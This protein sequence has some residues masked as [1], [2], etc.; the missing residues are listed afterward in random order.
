[1]NILVLG[2]VILDIFYFSRSIRNAPEDPTVPIQKVESTEYK[3]GGAANVALNLASLGANVTLLGVIGGDKEGLKLQSLLSENSFLNAQL[4]C[5]SDKPTTQKHRVFEKLRKNNKLISR[6][7]IESTEDLDIDN[8]RIVCSYVQEQSHNFDAIVF[9]DYGKGFLTQTLCLSVIDFAKANGIL[10]FVD[11]KLK[12][13]NKFA[14]CF[15]F[16]PNLNEARIITGELD[17]NRIITRLLNQFECEN[18]VIT[19]GNEGLVLYEHHKGSTTEIKCSL[20]IDPVQ[21]VTGAGDIVIV[22]LV[23]MY[24]ASK[25]LNLAAN[26]ANS[27]A[28]EKGVQNIG[29]YIVKKEDIEEAICKNVLHQ[30]T[31]KTLYAGILGLFRNFHK[32]EKIVFTNGCFDILHS[33]HIECLQ[34]AKKQGDILIVGLN[35]D[36]SV[37]QLKGP[38]RPINAVEERSKMLAL[39]DF[40]DFVVVFD[41][42]TPIKII[43]ELK[44]DVL[45]KGGDYKNIESIVGFGI[46]KEIILFDYRENKSSSTVI[47]KI[48]NQ[49]LT[50]K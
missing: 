28:S 1:M 16:K 41:D 19:K 26:I 30:M 48:E 27:V 4:F 49:I 10:T 21:D 13:V 39:F 8:V 17:T 43:E 38:K 32:K 20:Q 35:S 40:V 45:V 18:I 34:F 46:A 42:E 2:D 50:K 31:N 23:Y 24:L 25:D 36:K 3:V 15:C 12:Y 37:S 29:N 11:P 5:L 7:D 22:V 14:R 9:S 33:A 47:K 6:F 44:P